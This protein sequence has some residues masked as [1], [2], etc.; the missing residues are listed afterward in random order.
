MDI[1][2]IETPNFRA[3]DPITSELAGKEHTKSGK[4]QSDCQRIAELVSAYQGR[5][6]RELSKLSGI[7]NEVIH[8]RL[9]EIS[10]V[11]KG[12]KRKCDVTG[13]VAYTW[14]VRVA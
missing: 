6:S 2:K 12:A 14:F 5:T 4:R 11:S 13:R 3:T 1:Q 8:K 7:E 10:I 9:S